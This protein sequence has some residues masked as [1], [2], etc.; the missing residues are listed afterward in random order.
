MFIW[1]GVLILAF[2]TPTSLE[3]ALSFH[4]DTI[5]DKPGKQKIAPLILAAAGLLSIVLAIIPTSPSPRGL[6]A[7]FLGLIGIVLPLLLSLSGEVGL[8]QILYLVMFVGL[9]MLVP[10][11]LI[12]NEYRESMLPRI[13]VTVGVLCVLALYLI[14]VDDKLGIVGIFDRLIDGEGKQKILAIFA[15]LPIIYAVVSLLVWLPSPSTGLGKVMAWLW[16]TL[17]PLREITAF[18]INGNIGAQ[19]EAS[20][21]KSLMEWAPVSGYLVL[22]GY[23]FATV[24]GKQLE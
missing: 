12:R 10:G 19:I 14:P 22:L 11:L 7:G 4:W 24:L 18:L 5:I 9:I 6:L 2:L 1:G 15:L 17:F 20:P 3:P 13:L 16:I 23:G 8:G 21:F